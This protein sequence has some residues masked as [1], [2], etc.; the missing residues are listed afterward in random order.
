MRHFMLMEIVHKNVSTYLKVATVIVTC[1][2][3]TLCFA[4]AFLFWFWLSYFTIHR[5]RNGWLEFSLH[6][7]RWWKVKRECPRRPRGMAKAWH[8]LEKL[9]S[10]MFRPEIPH[11][12]LINVVYFSCSDQF[13][14][15]DVAFSVLMTFSILMLHFLP[16]WHFLSWCCIFY[17]D[18]I[19]FFDVAFSTLMLLSTLMYHFFTLV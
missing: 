7:S 16:W 17:L 2:V 19:S 1:K 4:I 13:L 6:C 11:D 5:Y 18:D 10:L 12:E 3:K 15:L 8:M 14:F 9:I